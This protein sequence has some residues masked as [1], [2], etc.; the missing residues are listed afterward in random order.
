M[1]QDV[2]TK[3]GVDKALTHTPW[4]RPICE[5]MLFQWWEAL[6][7]GNLKDFIDDKEIRRM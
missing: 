7:K 5:G 3:T 2:A 6:E 4:F 1:F